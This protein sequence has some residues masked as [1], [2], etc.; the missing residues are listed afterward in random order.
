M[1]EK[2]KWSRLSPTPFQLSSVMNLKN[3]FFFFAAAFLTTFLAAGFFFAGAFLATFLAAAFFAGFLAA[4]FFAAGFAAGLAT[5]FT[6]GFGAGPSLRS[7]AI[8]SLSAFAGRK[9]ASLMP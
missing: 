4:A 8:T 9:R 7:P 2:Q 1:C 6:S 3:Y 5:G